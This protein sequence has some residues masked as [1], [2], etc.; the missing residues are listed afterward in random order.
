[1]KCLLCAAMLSCNESPSLVYT[2]NHVRNEVNTSYQ[3]ASVLH[4]FLQFFSVCV[5]CKCGYYVLVNPDVA[6]SVTA[7]HVVLANVNDYCHLC[8]P[9]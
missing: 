2:R 7:I 3:Q 1:M 6:V 5:H 8:A 4:L 9:H